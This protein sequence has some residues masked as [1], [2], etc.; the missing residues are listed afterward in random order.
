[1]LTHAVFALMALPNILL[2]HAAA[3]GQLGPE[4]D[5]L[6]LSDDFIA[7]FRSRLNERAIELRFIAG[8]W[9]TF[10]TDQLDHVAHLVLTSETVYRDASIPALVSLL[11]ST[12]RSDATTLVAAKT[13]Y[14][15]LD[16]GELAFR[17]R[18]DKAAID[19]VWRT[20]AGGIERVVLDVRW[21]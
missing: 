2:A 4:E 16:G 13:V 6:E 3:S 15:G 21:L 8:D 9:T 14:F 18:A 7:G 12:A 11:R 10:S 5:T 19:E 17:R 20:E 1:M